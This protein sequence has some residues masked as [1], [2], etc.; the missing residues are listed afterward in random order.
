MKEKGNDER[1]NKKNSIRVSLDHTD[2]I[3]PL[4]SVDGPGI[5]A[6]DRT[7][8][9]TEETD[10]L[11]DDTE[12]I[13]EEAM[14]CQTVQLQFIIIPTTMDI[15]FITKTGFRSQSIVIIMRDCSRRWM[16]RQDT[17]DMITSR[18]RRRSHILL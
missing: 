7:E 17:R 12:V 1:K 14:Y 18:L 16:E 8:A 5:Q 6:E 9:I 15:I 10:V 3:C 11:S 13:T 2:H 4:S